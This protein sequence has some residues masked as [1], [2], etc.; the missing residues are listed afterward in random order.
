[1]KSF[2][3]VS[4]IIPVFNGERH[5]AEAL[6]SVLNQTFESFEVIV[7]DDCSTDSTSKIVSQYLYAD[8]RI[9]F[10]GLEVNSNLPSIPRNRGLL[11][12]K[13]EYVAFLDHDDTWSP[14]KLDRQ[15]KVLDSNPE[16]ALVHSHLLTLADR[17]AWL[18]IRN[19]PNPL[20]LDSS[21]QALRRNNVLICSAVVGRTKVFRLLGGFDERP[22]LRSV[23]DY[24]LWLRISM[25][26]IIAYVP[27]IHGR[28]RLSNASTSAMENMPIRYQYLNINEN[29]L[30]D[31]SKEPYT[32]R[33]RL[34]FVNFPI[35]IC[36]YLIEGN[37][38]RILRI[39]PR[40]L[41]FPN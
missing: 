7:V 19:L 33:I 25:Q 12:A 27:E 37:F 32:T 31:K 4:I 13:G 8:S 40:V 16:I 30:L 22:E 17:G 41:T 18:G 24:Q 6:D 5:I 21:Y 15:V 36:F 38:R 35:A 10:I 28:Y 1:M 9:R 20:K 14:W 23:E 39:S 3:R 29:T 34:K 26:H 2:P 11:E